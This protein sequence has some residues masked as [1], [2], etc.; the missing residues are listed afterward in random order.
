[1][2]GRNKE[3]VLHCG[4]EEAK[5]PG[6]SLS[7]LRYKGT[8]S[9]VG[10]YQLDQVPYTMCCQSRIRPDHFGGYGTAFS[11]CRSGSVSIATKRKAELYFFQ[12][13]KIN[14]LNYI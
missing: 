4:G 9:T 11:D 10:M 1:V 14:C 5:R 7:L 12:E 6:G 13:I 2:R 3:D 8:G